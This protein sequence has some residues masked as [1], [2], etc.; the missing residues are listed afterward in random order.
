METPISKL[1]PRMKPINGCDY[2]FTC[3]KDGYLFNDKE[4]MPIKS[5][6]FMIKHMHKY[7]SEIDTKK[8]YGEYFAFDTLLPNTPGTNEESDYYKKD[9][10]RYAVTNLTFAKTFHLYSVFMDTEL[11]LEW[12]P[13]KDDP[14]FV[15]QKIPKHMRS[16]LLLPY[17]FEGSEDYI[18]MN[19]GVINFQNQSSVYVFG[20]VNDDIITIRH[21]NMLN[22]EKYN[23]CLYAE[24]MGN[25]YI[26]KFR[27]DDNENML[28]GR[29]TICGYSDL[30][31]L[32]KRIYSFNE[33]SYIKFLVQNGYGYDNDRLK[34][35]HIKQ[36]NLYGFS[37]NDDD[38][39]DDFIKFG[40]SSDRFDDHRD[41]Y[42]GF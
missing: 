2:I 35:D 26:C 14:L 21:Y 33:N 42:G 23:I 24:I 12:Q 3:N 27:F 22:K 36:S 37:I 5:L 13:E 38:D 32:H 19:D 6:Y 9:V 34:K 41:I 31:V 25:N 18:M 10:L 4:K 39:M 29:D 30:S 28:F 1:V 7:V 17:T 40:M 16:E 15:Y 8:I 11:K 20:S